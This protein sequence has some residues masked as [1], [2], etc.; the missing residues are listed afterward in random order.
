VNARGDTAPDAL[1]AEVEARDEALR[2]QT[3]RELQEVLAK[4]GM[5][6]A[7]ERTMEAEQAQSCGRPGCPVTC[8][9]PPL[10]DSEPSADAPKI[11]QWRDGAG[12]WGG[13]SIPH[14]AELVLDP[15]LSEPCRIHEHDGAFKCFTHGRKWGAILDPDEACGSVAA[16]GEPDKR[17][18]WATQ[19]AVRFALGHS[20]LGEFLNEVSEIVPRASIGT[21]SPSTRPADPERCPACTGQPLSRACSAG[22]S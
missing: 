13:F 9:T 1:L 18:E 3:V 17:V 6:L 4:H 15:K 12:N 14:D 11:L 10:E 22:G 8:R 19:A 2:E 7:V 5:R 16:G 21:P 20:N